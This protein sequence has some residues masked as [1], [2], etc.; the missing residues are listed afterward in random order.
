MQWAWKATSVPRAGD[1]L[2]GF[3]FERGIHSSVCLQIAAFFIGEVR[4]RVNRIGRVS[5]NLIIVQISSALRRLSRRE[6]GLIFL[7]LFCDNITASPRVHFMLGCQLDKCSLA[8]CSARPLRQKERRDHS[9]G[10]LPATQFPPCLLPLPGA[11]RMVSGWWQE[12]QALWIVRYLPGGKAIS[13]LSLVCEEG[14]KFFPKYN[15]LMWIKCAL[16]WV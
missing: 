9:V 4:Q 8:S 13:G 10:S 14:R 6:L 7:R 5:R 1:L 2:Y 16:T 15:L 3:F 12:H 11:A